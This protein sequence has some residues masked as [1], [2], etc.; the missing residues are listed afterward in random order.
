MRQRADACPFSWGEPLFKNFFPFPLGNQV[1]FRFSQRK[2]FLF[3]TN[4]VLV[5]LFMADR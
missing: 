2:F 4:A 5:H 1:V 3:P